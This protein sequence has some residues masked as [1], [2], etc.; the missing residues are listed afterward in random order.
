[1]SDDDLKCPGCGVMADKVQ[2]NGWLFYCVPCKWGWGH[3][4]IDSREAATD[5]LHDLKEPTL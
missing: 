2:P 5:F 4:Q 3:P 1:M